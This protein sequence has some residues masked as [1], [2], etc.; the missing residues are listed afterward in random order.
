MIW[1]DREKHLRDI[2]VTVRL[3]PAEKQLIDEAAKGPGLAL[4]HRVKKW[5]GEV[6]YSR[7]L[8]AALLEKAR[9]AI[10]AEAADNRV[11][12]GTGSQT[13]S[14]SEKSDKKAAAKKSDARSRGGRR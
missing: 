2:R 10:A 11:E 8:R 4:G 14:S 6:M 12:P 5:N 1:H 13:F 3:S 9:A 7:A